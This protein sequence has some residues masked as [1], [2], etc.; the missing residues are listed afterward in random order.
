MRTVIAV[1]G[2]P[3]D[4]T[5]L[6][7]RGKAFRFPVTVIDRE[8]LGTPR[9]ISKSVSFE[10][11]AEISRSRLSTW[12]LGEDEVVK[13]LFEITK[14]HLIYVLNSMGWRSE[15]LAVQVNTDT[16]K[17]A[18]PFDSSIIQDPAGA[19]LQV[20]INRPIGFLG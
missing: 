9:Q 20:E 13:V 10:I 4:V 15:D 5:R 14:D 17:G 2:I 11:M 12:G 18:C 19:V 8:Y 3:E 7:F 1:F 16:H 6:G